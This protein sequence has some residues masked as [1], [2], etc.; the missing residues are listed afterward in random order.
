MLWSGDVQQCP[1]KSRIFSPPLQKCLFKTRYICMYMYAYIFLSVYC[2]LLLPFKLKETLAWSPNLIRW[3]PVF[4]YLIDG[5]CIHVYIYIYIMY[6]YI[7][8]NLVSQF[9]SETH[10]LDCNL[11]VSQFR[12]HFSWLILIGLN[13]VTC[14]LAPPPATSM[15]TYFMFSR[16]C[17]ILLYLH[18]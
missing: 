11:M 8:Y 2:N 10:N 1:H 3:S 6:I 7:L 17:L 12:I 14:M 4:N 15:F 13:I 16:Y 5:T 9:C 18:V